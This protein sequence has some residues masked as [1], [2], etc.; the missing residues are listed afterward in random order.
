MPDTDQRSN[1]L[2]LARSSGLVADTD[3][4][5]APASHEMY[6]MQIETTLGLLGRAL[7][8]VHSVVIDL[9][10]AHDDLRTIAP[11][12]I[13]QQVRDMSPG[14][15]GSPGIS[16]AYAHMSRTELLSALAGGADA[17]TRRSDA[18][19]LLQGMPTLDNLRLNAFEV[20]GFEQW[21]SVNSG[22]RHFDLAVASRDVVERCGPNGVAVLLDAYGLDLVDPVRL[23]WYSLAL[24]LLG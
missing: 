5:S 19:V 2:G 8:M 18:A 11:A 22:D 14:P 9:P 17:V 3:S 16:S 10:D 21:E 12:T 15:S 4:D 1:L 7:S 13:L 20:R 6:L 23:D 24:E